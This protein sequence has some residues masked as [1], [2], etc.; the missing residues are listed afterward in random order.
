MLT[1]EPTAHSALCRTHVRASPVSSANTVRDRVRQ[2]RRRGFPHRVR[3]STVI[4]AT[5]RPSVLRPGNRYTAPAEG[6]GSIRANRRRSAR[7]RGSSATQGIS[8]EQKSAMSG[9]RRMGAVFVA[10][11]SPHFGLILRKSRIES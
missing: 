4:S 2:V 6:G 7:F 9:I 8:E 3:S 1:S 10:G 5:N 11:V